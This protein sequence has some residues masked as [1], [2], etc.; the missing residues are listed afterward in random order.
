MLNIKH[1]MCLKLNRLEI[2]QLEFICKIL[3]KFPLSGENNT[4]TLN[5]RKT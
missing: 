5:P 1:L 2:R 3:N 4:V